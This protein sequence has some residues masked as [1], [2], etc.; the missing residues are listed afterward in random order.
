MS[1]V[2]EGGWGAGSFLGRRLLQPRLPLLPARLQL[3]RA[4]LKQCFHCQQPHPPTCDPLQLPTGTDNVPAPAAPRRPRAG[5]PAV[6][7]QGV[8]SS[9]MLAEMF[10]AVMGAIYLD[11]DLDAVRRCYVQH[12]PLPADPLSLLQ[13]DGTGGG[14]AG[15][16][17]L[18]GVG[19]AASADNPWE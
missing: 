19:G 1:D 17:W 14:T 2:R 8:P 6:Q 10:E 4:A 11:G 13:A 16:S 12:F 7:Q 5:R 3:S 18:S 9:N 15:S